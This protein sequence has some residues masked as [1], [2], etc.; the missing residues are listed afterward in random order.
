MVMVSK[1]FEF[2][3]MFVIADAT[4]DEPSSVLRDRVLKLSIALST[5]P[6]N[7]IIPHDVINESRQQAWSKCTGVV[8][9][10]NDEK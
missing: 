3:G 4:A 8:Y 9:L 10:T 1:A 2:G 7:A 6:R 5:C